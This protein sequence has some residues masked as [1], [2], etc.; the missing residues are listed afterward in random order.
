[1]S[2]VKKQLSNLELSAFCQQIAMILKT[3]L[4][5]Y[6]GISILC[7]EAAYENN[8]EFLEKIYKPMEQGSTLYETI[9]DT[10]YFPRYMVNMIK[11]GEETGHLE[12]VLTALSNY[13]EREESIKANISASLTYPLILCFMMLIVM[14]VMISKVLPVFS[15]IYKELGSELTGSAKILMNISNFINQYLLF[16]VAIIIVVTFLLVIFFRSDFGKI[17]YQGH[18]LSMSIAA[19]R[20]A[21]SMYLAL[22]SGLDTDKGLDLAYELVGN[23]HMQE[24]ISNCKKHIAHGETFQDAVLMS[25]IFSKIYSS[26]VAIGYK[27]G[28]MDEV[29]KKISASYEKNT[30]KKLSHLLSLIEPTLVII[31]CVLVGIILISFLLPLLGIMS[32]IG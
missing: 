28:A 11:L 16:I 14:I 4:P 24:K 26:W 25:G 3:G 7:D 1:M 30:D 12:D 10:E 17:I 8:K 5:A 9:K 15:K 31:L 27:T 20:F 29:M 2:K 21:N 32:N 22:R 13:Y 6:Y 19:S 23:T 18:S